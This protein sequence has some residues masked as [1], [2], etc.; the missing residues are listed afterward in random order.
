MAVSVPSRT[1]PRWVNQVVSVLLRTPGIQRWL[2]RS[3]ALVRFRGRKTGRLY[4]TPVS[5][6]GKGGTILV[7]SRIDRSWWKNLEEKPDV[8]LRLAGRTFR[9]LARA[10]VGDEAEIPALAS[11]LETRRADAKAFGVSFTRDGRA[12]PK[13]VRDLLARLAVIRISLR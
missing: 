5:Y 6:Y 1:P 11:F 13:D 3:V 7:L 4:T 8:E 2:G 9:G 12:D 10:S